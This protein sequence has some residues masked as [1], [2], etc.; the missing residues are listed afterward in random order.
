MYQLMRLSS[1]REV[2]GCFWA[3]M[4]IGL[5]TFDPELASFF[6]VSAGITTG[7]LV[8]V[9]ERISRPV[10]SEGTDPGI[11]GI[12]PVVVLSVD[13]IDPVTRGSGGCDIVVPCSICFNETKRLYAISCSSTNHYSEKTGPAP[14]FARKIGQKG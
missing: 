7:I 13:G 9:C 2:L 12:L 1:L 6:F 5:C 11:R 3:G 14:P 8:L 10:V 4:T